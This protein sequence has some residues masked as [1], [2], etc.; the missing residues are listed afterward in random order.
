MKLTLYTIPGSHPCKVVETALAIKGLEYERVDMLPGIAQAYQR[1]AFGKRT[2]PGLRIGTERV[3]GSRLILRALEGLRPEPALVPA[4]PEHR[5]AVDAAEAWGDDELQGKARFVLLYA[6]SL[7]PDAG[8]S[9]IAGSKIPEFPNWLLNRMMRP[10]FKGELMMNR[11]SQSGIEQAVRAIPSLIDRVDALIAD[12]TIGGDEPNVADLQIAGSVR[13]LLNIDDV[14]AFIDARPAGE[15]ARRVIPDYA[16]H[17]PAGTL[18]AEWLP[19]DSRT[20]EPAPA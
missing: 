7:R 6:L 18:P 3:V 20:P 16:G 1:F 4:G 5:A 10:T 9:F 11:A 15:H 17:V 19:A 8:K 14:R 13:L 12:G 2:V